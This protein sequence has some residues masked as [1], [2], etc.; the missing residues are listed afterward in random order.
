[1]GGCVVGAGVILGM[2]LLGLFALLGPGSPLP[3]L[4]RALLLLALSLASSAA[5]F[6]FGAGRGEPGE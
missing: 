6:A 4:S 5:S 3:P 2:A 1:M